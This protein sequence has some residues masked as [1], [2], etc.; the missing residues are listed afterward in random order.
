MCLVGLF[1]LDKFGSLALGF[2]LISGCGM[3]SVFH[4]FYFFVL[5]VGFKMEPFFNRFKL[6]DIPKPSTHMK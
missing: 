6:F 4:I 3:W 2:N 1:V 5:G